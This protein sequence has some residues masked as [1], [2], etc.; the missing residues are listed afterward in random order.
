MA[1]TL[2]RSLESSRQTPASAPGLLGRRRDSSVRIMRRAYQKTNPA[3]EGAADRSTGSASLPRGRGRSQVTSLKSQVSNRPGALETCSLLLVTCLRQHLDHDA[4]VLRATRL[5]LVRRHRLL[6]AV[7][8]HAHLVQRDLVLL[9]EIALNRFGALEADL[10]VDRLRADVVGVAFDLDPDVL[11]I[12]FEL[13]DH[14][15]DLLL[16]FVRQH[17]LAELEVARILVQD[18]FVDETAVRLVHLV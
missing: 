13:S 1:R 3:G 17:R 9:V 11:R 14:L 5:R 18:D 10:L 12:L 8:D 15:V 2:T 7:T 16:R 6:G 4:A